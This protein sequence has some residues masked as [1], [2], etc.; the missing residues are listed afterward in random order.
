[1]PVEMTFVRSFHCERVPLLAFA[2]G[3]FAALDAAKLSHERS[4]GERA[5]Q[6]QQQGAARNTQR[7]LAPRGKDDRTVARDQRDQRKAMDARAG[8]ETLYAVD[9]R[10]HAYRGL[11]DHRKL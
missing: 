11:H 6:G 7:L 4:D 8:D 9:G 5:E 1:M 2:P 10:A 3:A